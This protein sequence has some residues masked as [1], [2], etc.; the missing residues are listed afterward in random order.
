MVTRPDDNPSY[1]FLRTIL[2][3]VM[4]FLLLGAAILMCFVIAM[5]CRPLI[6]PD[7]TV[8]LTVEQLS[9]TRSRHLRFVEVTDFHF[10]DKVFISRELKANAWVVTLPSNVSLLGT[11]WQARENR[12]I[13]LKFPE[14]KHP[15]FMQDIVESNKI[16][17]E[18]YRFKSIASEQTI[19]RIKRRF[20]AV[21]IDDVWVVE[22][23]DRRFAPSQIAAAFFG[24]FLFLIMSLAVVY[25]LKK[26]YAY[27]P[28]AKW[29]KP[30]PLPPPAKPE[31]DEMGWPKLPWEN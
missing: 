28:Y 11:D 29:R 1:M 12:L 25:V 10:D 3:T 16:Y 18:V 19:D 13:V 27:D 24:S 22:C 17:G 6:N 26:H 15:A 4:G 23:L 8:Q 30:P 9:E 2:Q 20:P 31:L 21:E 7:G 14:A 5:L